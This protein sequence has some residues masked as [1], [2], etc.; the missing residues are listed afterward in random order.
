MVEWCSGGDDASGGDSGGVGHMH[1]VRCWSGV[2]VL[3]MLVAMIVVV[4]V[5]CIQ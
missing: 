2:A 3:M 1:T 5:I 4:S